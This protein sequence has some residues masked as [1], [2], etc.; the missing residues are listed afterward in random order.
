VSEPLLCGLHENLEGDSNLVDGREGVGNWSR[1]VPREPSKGDLRAVLRGIS[2]A[3]ESSRSV[4]AE[5]PLPEKLAA[6]VK[7]LQPSNDNDR[8]ANSEGGN[9]TQEAED[10]FRR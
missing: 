5:E 2:R 7:R 9:S 8:H 3:L 6:L 1:P 10:S 4:S